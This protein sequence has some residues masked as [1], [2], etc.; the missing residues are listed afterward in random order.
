MAFRFPLA[1]ILHY[2]QSLEHQQELRVR[3]A[4]QHAARV[5]RAIDQLQ[6]RVLENKSE[7]LQYLTDGTTAAEIRFSL[8]REA[9]LRQHHQE[10]LRELM[11][12]QKVRDQQQK[13]FQQARRERE[14]YESLRDHQLHEY[15]RKAR[16]R[17]QRELDDLFLLRQSYLRRG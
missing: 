7:R 12:V 11:R 3:E 1:A 10:L 2:R 13:L 9:A 16:R 17:E 4:N 8:M 6:Q 5:R 15:E 14:T